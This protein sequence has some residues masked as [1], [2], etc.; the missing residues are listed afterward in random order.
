MQVV[1]CSVE[2]STR[3]AKKGKEKQVKDMQNPK[4]KPKAIDM[5]SIA[6]GGGNIEVESSETKTLGV[7]KYII[8]GGKPCEG[9][10][11]LFIEMQEDE[12]CEII[13][14]MYDVFRIKFL[15][16]CSNTYVIVFLCCRDMLRRTSN[17]V[18]LIATYPT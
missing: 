3:K 11:Q 1:E 17:N 15:F 6:E 5:A 9:K 14:G 4:K 12:I 8:H 2:P 16:T 10:T 18:N 7:S 13:E